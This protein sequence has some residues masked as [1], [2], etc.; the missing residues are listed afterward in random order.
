VHVAKTAIPRYLRWSEFPIVFD[1]RNHLDRIP[2]I[3][4]YPLIV[5]AI[6]GSERLSKVLMDGGSD[7]NIM[8]IETFDGLGIASSTLRPSSSLFHGIN[9]DH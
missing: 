5:E 1:Y 2:H 6:M 3:G 9:L 8:Y 4:A 7:L